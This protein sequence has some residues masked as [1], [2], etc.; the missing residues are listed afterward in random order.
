GQL[1]ARIRLD[2][3][4]ADLAA[5]GLVSAEEQLLAGLA[6]RIKG[7]RN[8]RSSEGAVGEQAAVFAGKGHALGDALVDDV[9][10]HLGEPVNVRFAG[11][12][13]A[14][15]DGIVKKPIHAVA[16]V[17]VILGGVDA[18]LGGDAVRPARTVLVT[19][20]AHLI[21]QFGE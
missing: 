6:A 11:T 1:R 13:V 18:P 5:E 17:L 2:G 14:A 7:A 8:L 3:A 12:E 4:Q 15:F 9:H 16:V 20:A 10:A 21:T 19:E